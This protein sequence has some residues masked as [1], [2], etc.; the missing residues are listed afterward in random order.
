MHINNYKWLKKFWWYVQKVKFENLMLMF[1]DESTEEK[2]TLAIEAWYRY[3]KSDKISFKM[4]NIK[5]YD[6]EGDLYSQNWSINMAQRRLVTVFFF[7]FN[8][9]DK[10]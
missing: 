8:S 6:D 2:K 5:D 9:L 7:A 4:D 1:S 10:T 3:F